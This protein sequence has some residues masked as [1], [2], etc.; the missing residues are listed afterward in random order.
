MYCINV[1]WSCNA[2]LGG[3]CSV[4]NPESNTASAFY[5]PVLVAQHTVY[6]N[7]LTWSSGQLAATVH[8]VQ[9]AVKALL[10]GHKRAMLNQFCP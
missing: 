10:K 8:I 4:L 1:W 3:T 7:I 9:G 2:L 6:E 5:L